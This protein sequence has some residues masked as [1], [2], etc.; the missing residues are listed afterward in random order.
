MPDGTLSGTPGDSDV[1]D[2]VFIVRA[3]DDGGLSNTA[4]MHINV[5][6]TF[7]GVSGLEDLAGLAD[8]WL[9]T[10]CTDTPACDGADLDG[11][12]DVNISDLGVLSRRW[13]D[14]ECSSFTKLEKLTARRA[15]IP[16][17]PPGELV[18]GRSG[19]RDIGAAP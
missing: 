6:N 17:W 16:L 18:N 4:T 9:A 5:I 12:G 13:L 15:T 1:G 14:D 3:T 8:Q 10:G 19:R 7:S 11:D 2:N